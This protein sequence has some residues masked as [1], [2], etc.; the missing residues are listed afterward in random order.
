MILVKRK[1][2][3]SILQVLERKRL[4]TLKSIWKT[5]KM[6]PLLQ[7]QSMEWCKEFLVG[8]TISHIS[9]KLRFLKCL[10]HFRGL[11]E[12]YPLLKWWCNQYRKS[13]FQW[14][15]LSHLLSLS[16]IR[17]WTLVELLFI[18]RFQWCAKMKSPMRM[19]KWR[20]RRKVEIRIRKSKRNKRRKRKRLTTS[21]TASSS[22]KLTLTLFQ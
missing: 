18:K 12:C 13:P 17:W 16:K 6:F 4:A 14:H 2:A 22:R 15:H 7:K 8:S 9:N 3:Q 10:K 11:L 19:L 1:K 21:W 5:K 20:F